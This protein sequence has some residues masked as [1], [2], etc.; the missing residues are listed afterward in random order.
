RGHTRGLIVQTRDSVEFLTAGPHKGGAS[1]DSDFRQGLEAVRDKAGADDIDSPYPFLRESDQG[2]HR[3]RF[4]PCGTAEPRLK[5]HETIFA[6]KTQLAYDQPRGFL[7]MA[8]VRVAAVQ[9]APG[10]AV[11]R[12]HELVR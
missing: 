6:A 4:Q 12:Q 5:C 11:K 9:H 3:V 10:N 1:L 2:G 7:T 8:M